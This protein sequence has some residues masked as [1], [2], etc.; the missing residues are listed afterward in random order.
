[1]DASIDR[2]YVLVECELERLTALVDTLEAEHEVTMI[3]EPSTCLTMVPAEDSIENQAF[4][5]GEALTTECEVEVEGHIGYG[6]C[7]GE[8]PERAYALA[9]VDALVTEHL[10]PEAIETFLVEQHRKLEEGERIEAAHVR[11]TK[12]DFKLFD[13]E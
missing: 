2:D 7:L 1:M 11:R 10:V 5:L 6:V 3:K 12:V 9:V 4:Y 8:E 13:E